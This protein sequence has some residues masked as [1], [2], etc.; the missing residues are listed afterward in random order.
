[1]SRV[2]VANTLL[3]AKFAA[4]S[5]K[6]G[7]R[8]II[9]VAEE[10]NLPDEFLNYIKDSK[11]SEWIVRDCWKERLTIFKDDLQEIGDI[12]I[13]RLSEKAAM[14]IPK[15]F[16]HFTEY[17]INEIIECVVEHNIKSLY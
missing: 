11:Y 2:R 10:L 1:V 8:K 13:N 7:D 16:Q 4:P 3:G 14:L 9:D 17:T 5:S 12:K 6:Y 15:A